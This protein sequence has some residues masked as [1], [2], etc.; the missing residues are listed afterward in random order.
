MSKLARHALTYFATAGV[1]ALLLGGA[2]LL[3][4]VDKYNDTRVID[5]P[6]A[7]A[8]L[9]AL[10]LGQ[11][12]LNTGVIA[13]AATRRGY[14]PPLL[15]HIPY[16]KTVALIPAYNEEGRVGKVVSEAKKH[17]ELV[18]VVDDGS[19]DATAAEAE[20]AG[21][22]VIKHPRNMGYGAAVL[23]LMHAALAANAEYAV[24]LDADGQHD[25]K[26][27]PKFIQALEN[28]ADIAIG[29]R[30]TQ[31][32][33]P[34]HRKLGIAMIRLLLRLLGIKVKDPE[35]GYRA[36]KRQALKTLTSELR[37]TWMGISSQTA[38]IAS[39]RRMKVAEVPTR[40]SYSPGTSTEN[41]LS[42]GVSILWT[43]TWTWLTEKPLRTLAIGATLLAASAALLSYA[44]IIFNA[45]RYIRLTY[46]TLGILSEIAATTLISIAASTVALATKAKA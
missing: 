33:V 38:Y 21:A 24:L 34:A 13:Y 22:L 36:F 37:E 44:A 32:N 8:T 12:L 11:T 42:H 23:T 2:L 30:F 1:A 5:V 16:A 43:I 17:V 35:N 3:T 31:S 25:P 10:A 4:L 26:D 39:R 20:Q 29:N 15:P 19:T 18:I 9:L 14:T 28:G 7:A 27:I 41:P 6:H 46:T 45:A 40:V